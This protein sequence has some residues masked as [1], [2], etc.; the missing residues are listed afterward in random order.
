MHKLVWSESLSVGHYDIDKQ[1]QHLMDIVNEIGAIDCDGQDA[2]QICYDLLNKLSKNAMGHF[3]LEEQLLKRAGAVDI[4]SQIID[5]NQFFLMTKRL[6]ANLQ[7]DSVS[8]SALHT[9]LSESFESH[10]TGTDR[11]FKP[12]FM[13]LRNSLKMGTP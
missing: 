8:I 7:K 1:H 4:S 11:E 10:L 9:E 6:T 13:R 3:T 2:K 12:V 5:H